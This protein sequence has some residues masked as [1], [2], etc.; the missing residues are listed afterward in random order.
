MTASKTGSSLVS[1]KTPQSSRESEPEHQP[2]IKI[3]SSKDLN[4]NAELS[5][6][7]KGGRVKAVS[8]GFATASKNSRSN[9]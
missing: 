4:G 6:H 9:H 5:E 2:Q 7:G 8:P 1:N 3:S